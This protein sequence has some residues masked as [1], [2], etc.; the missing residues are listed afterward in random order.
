MDKV[1]HGNI[2]VSSFRSDAYA[3][4]GTA[5]FIYDMWSMYKVHI[6]K[7]SDKLKLLSDNGSLG[8]C[9]E[10]NGLLYDAVKKNGNGN[11]TSA[12]QKDDVLKRELKRFNKIPTEK[13]SFLYYC[14]T[15]PVMTIHHV[16]LGSF[17]LLV[18]VVGSNTIS[19]NVF[20]SD[21]I[22]YPNV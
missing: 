22:V 15:N 7:I 4:F 1:H 8:D 6:Q 12:L 16:F 18:I 2:F 5:Y 11:C 3:W 17:G 13:P 19:W 21:Q 20:Q 9:K 14:L 10:T